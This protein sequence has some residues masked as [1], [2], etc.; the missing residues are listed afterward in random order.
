MIKIKLN[1]VTKLYCWISGQIKKNYNH[2]FLSYWLGEKQV[3][4]IVLKYSLS[5]STTQSKRSIIS[6]SCVL[7]KF[8]C[9]WKTVLVHIA[10]YTSTIKW[11]NT[12][13]LVFNIYCIIYLYKRSVSAWLC[14]TKSSFKTYIFG[15]VGTVQHVQEVLYLVYKVS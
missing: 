10:S 4:K 12:K 8:F 9:V 11:L 7:N 6:I 5:N 1:F 14:W 15:L 2:D 13:L 3:C